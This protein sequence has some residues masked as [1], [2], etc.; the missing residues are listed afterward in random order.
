MKLSICRFSGIVFAVLLILAGCP[1][2]NTDDGITSTVAFAMNSVEQSAAADQSINLISAIQ[3]Q[4]IESTS[5]NPTLTFDSASATVTT[6]SVTVSPDANIAL[7]AADTPAQT[8]EWE[9]DF[10]ASAEDVKDEAS[11]PITVKKFADGSWTVDGDLQFVVENEAQEDTDVPVEFAETKCDAEGNVADGKITAQSVELTPEIIDALKK[12]VD[13][14]VTVAKKDEAKTADQKMTP[15][16][17]PSSTRKR[18]FK[19][20]STKTA[21][22]EYTDDEAKAAEHL[23]KMDQELATGGIDEYEETVEETMKSKTPTGA[24]YSASFTYGNKQTSTYSRPAGKQHT[25]VVH[26]TTTDG[27]LTVDGTTVKFLGL[28]MTYNSEYEQDDEEIIPPLPTDSRPKFSGAIVINGIKIE[29]TNGVLKKLGEF[30]KDNNLA[31]NHE[32]VGVDYG[33]AFEGLSDDNKKAVIYAVHILT[34]LDGKIFTVEQDAL[35][36]DISFKMKG[37]DVAADITQAATAPKKVTIAFTSGITGDDLVAT[38]PSSDTSNEWTISGASAGAA[39]T[40]PAST[41]GLATATEVTLTDIVYDSLQREIT[42]GSLTIGTTTI[43]A[44]ALK[45]ILLTPP[46]KR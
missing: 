38:P 27:E 41:D 36:T 29:I 9:I 6:N 32:N 30:M 40:I 21:N 19:S 8:D 5:A 22:N 12:L 11:S 28:G 42:S 1:A 44:T 39:I 23:N 14:F 10:A 31:G 7:Q 46:P 18:S 34:V 26:T 20:A 24:P 35:P 43:P 17:A 45:D 33:T 37:T 25:K 15:A 2:S 4:I 13:I 16:A 3:S